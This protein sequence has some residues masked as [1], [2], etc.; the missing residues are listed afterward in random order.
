MKHAWDSY[1]KYAWGYNELRPISRRAHFP[2]I[3]GS[4]PLGATIVDAIDTLYIM[5]LNKDFKLARDWIATKLNFDKVGSFF[6]KRL[7]HLAA[8]ARECL[9][10]SCCFFILFIRFVLPVLM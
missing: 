3:F 2:G 8:Y 9:Y 7:T 6:W 10:V 1:V 5:E 4:S